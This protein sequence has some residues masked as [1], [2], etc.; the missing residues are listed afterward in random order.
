MTDCRVP[1]CFTCA[2]NIGDD[3]SV[4]AWE[5][6]IR[7]TLDQQEAKE[8]RPL[9]PHRRLPCRQCGEAF[10]QQPISKPRRYCSERCRLLADGLRRKRRRAA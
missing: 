5:A 4:E 2:L 3:E 9:I 10:D 8:Q 6:R 7:A 1:T